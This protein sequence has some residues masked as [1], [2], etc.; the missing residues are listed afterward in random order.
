MQQLYPEQF[1][2]YASPHQSWRYT[3]FGNQ[4]QSWSQFRRGI[5]TTL[6]NDDNGQLKLEF[7][8]TDSF[9]YTNMGQDP[10]LSQQLMQTGG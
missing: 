5:F 1:N 4:L 7:V 2:S 6:E 9:I 3:E 10:Q 8:Q